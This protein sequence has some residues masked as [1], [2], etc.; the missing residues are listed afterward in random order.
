MKITKKGVN[1]NCKIV[2]EIFQKKKKTEYGRNRY[3]KM[4]EKDKQKL[5][6]Y[7]KSY[8]NSRKIIFLLSIL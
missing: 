6:Q 1:N 5:K 3:K 2:R 7:R 8:C 4:S